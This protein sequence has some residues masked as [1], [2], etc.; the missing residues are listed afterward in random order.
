[1][2][3]RTL[4]HCASSGTEG[5]P[6]RAC[7]RRALGAGVASLVGGVAL[8]ACGLPVGGEAHPVALALE[9]EAHQVG[10]LAVV[11]DD[12]DLRHRG[13]RGGTRLHPGPPAYRRRMKTV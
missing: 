7:T 12:Q 5:R 2:T 10:R 6:R 9:V 8:T 13:G 3:M 4:G 1:M 11:F